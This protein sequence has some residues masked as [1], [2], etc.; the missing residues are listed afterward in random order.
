MGTA[1]PKRGVKASYWIPEFISE[2]SNPEHREQVRK[3]IRAEITMDLGG[4]PPEGFFEAVEALIADFIAG[5]KYKTDEPTP[6]NVKAAI[7][8]L[9]GKV[10]ALSGMLSVDR[11]IDRRTCQFINQIWYLRGMTSNPIKECTQALDNLSAAVEMAKAKIATQKIPKGRKVDAKKD[12]VFDLFE[13]FQRFGL[14][15]KTTVSGSFEQCCMTLL[16]V[17]TKKEPSGN[18]IHRLVMAA[19]KRHRTA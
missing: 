12:F 5:T 11:G 6:A 1:K 10:D 15:P 14:K 8:E 9:G 4:P 16:H 3:E 18:N 7:A 13:L 2:I 17:A 19:A